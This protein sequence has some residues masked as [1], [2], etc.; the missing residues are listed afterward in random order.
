MIQ[1]LRHAAIPRPSF[2]SHGFL[3]QGP[4]PRLPEPCISLRGTCVSGRC[5]KTLDCLPIQIGGVAD[6]VHLLT[7]LSRTLA[8][9]EF[10][11]EIKRISTGWIQERGCLFR[12]FHWQAGYGCFSV[13]ESKIDAVTTS[14]S[15]KTAIKR[16]P[17]KTNTASCCAATGSHGTSLTCGIEDGRAHGGDGRN[18]VVVRP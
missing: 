6:H 2:D 4:R 9:A 3:H 16:S 18:H 15:R 11:K 14:P 1:I 8:I 13:S 10:V 5:A 12:Q 17:F 7:T